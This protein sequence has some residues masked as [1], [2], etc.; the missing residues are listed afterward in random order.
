MAPVWREGQAIE[1]GALLLKVAS[2]DSGLSASTDTRPAASYWTDAVTVVLR[3]PDCAR[4]AS[5]GPPRSFTIVP[6]RAWSGS[7]VTQATFKAAEDGS[8]V[9]ITASGPDKAHQIFLT[10]PQTKV[11][12]TK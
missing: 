2:R 7:G 12:Q 11:I 1:S 3:P 10:W 5:L 8:G 6:H 9:L 4:F